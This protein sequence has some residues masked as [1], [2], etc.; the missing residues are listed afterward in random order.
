MMYRFVSLLFLV[1]AGCGSKIHDS[2][3]QVLLHFT[4]TQDIDLID[5]SI[6]GE[7]PQYSIWLEDPLSGEIATVFVTQRTATGNFIG[8]SEVPVALPAWIKAF[9]QQTGRDDLPNPNDPVDMVS[10]A[11]KTNPRISQKVAVTAGKKWNYYIEMNLAGDFNYHFPAYQDN[12][13][14]DPHGN[15]QPSLIY[16]GEITANSGEVS[17]PELIG[18]TEQFYYSDKVNPDLEGIDSAKLVFTDIKVS[19]Q[20]L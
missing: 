9:Q 5:Q 14:P 1:L 6:Y 16:K 12:G 7:P 8:K 18:R 2:Q 20:D 13:A 3:K 15:G 11:T 19:C 17:I 10:G 4:M